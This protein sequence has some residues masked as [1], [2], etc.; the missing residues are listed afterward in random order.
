MKRKFVCLFILLC[1]GMMSMAAGD[2]NFKVGDI[3]YKILSSKNLTVEVSR[4]DADYSMS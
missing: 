1:S 2:D 3:Y 4:G